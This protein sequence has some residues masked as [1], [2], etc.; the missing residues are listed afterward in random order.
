MCRCA[1]VCAVVIPLMTIAIILAL[2]LLVIAVACA[3]RYAR[4]YCC[5]LTER[6]GSY[7]PS[8]SLPSY[9]AKADQRRAR[10]TRR[11]RLRAATKPTVVETMPTYRSVVVIGG[12]R[13]ARRLAPSNDPPKRHWVVRNADTWGNLSLVNNEALPPPPPPP[14]PSQT[15]VLGRR[16]P[17]GGRLDDDYDD[18]RKRSVPEIV[19]QLE[20]RVHYA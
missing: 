16:S 8:P 2:C 14:L 7:T 17:V 6:A 18:G 20:G 3:V 13:V 15:I 10:Q 12:D 19:S 5:C 4:K 1:C 11:P 9:R